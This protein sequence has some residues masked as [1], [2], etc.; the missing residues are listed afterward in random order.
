MDVMIDTNVIISAALFP[1]QR[2]N[3][4][5]EVVSLSHSLFLCSYTLEEIDRVIK[6]KFPNRM[7]A[8]EIF[9]RKLSFTLIHTPTVNVVDLDFSVRDGKDY[10]IIVSAIIADVDILITGDN[11]FDDVNVERPEIVTIAEFMNLYG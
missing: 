7:N 4:F 2:M 1:N 11:D 8:M 6:K 3:H 5:L 10:P 9:L